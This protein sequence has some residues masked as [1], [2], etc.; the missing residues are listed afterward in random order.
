MDK[1]LRNFGGNSETAWKQCFRDQ[2]S[3]ALETSEAKMERK[4]REWISLP[5]PNPHSLSITAT[6][7]VH[8]LPYSFFQSFLRYC[9]STY[10]VPGIALGARDEH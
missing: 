6:P 2:W 8:G 1:Q 9:L 10:C 3:S 4:Q 7:R 5:R